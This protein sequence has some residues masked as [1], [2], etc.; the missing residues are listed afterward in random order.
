MSKFWEG[1][2]QRHVI[3]VAAIYLIVGWIVVQVTVTAAPA[4]NLP[5]WFDTGIIFLVILGFPIALVLAWAFEVT[6]EGVKRSG[7]PGTRTEGLGGDEGKP[8]DEQEDAKPSIAVMPFANLSDDKDTEHLADGMTED[9]ITGLACN[10]HLFV[11]SRNATFVYKGKPIDLREV[12]RA[13]SVRYVLEG[14]VR[15]VGDRLRTTAQLIESKTG[16][17]LWAEKFDRPKVDIFDIQDEVI[18]EILGALGAQLLSAEAKRTKGRPTESL[19]AWELT[20]QAVL[21]WQTGD[22]K[23]DSSA[24]GLLEKAIEID[25]DYATAHALLA[26]VLSGIV[27]NGLSSNPRDDF[28]LAQDHLG[29]AISLDPEDP[30]TLTWVGNTYVYFGQH[31]KAVQFLRK[32]L[33]FNPTETVTILHLA[34]AHAYLGQFEESQKNFALARRLAPSGGWSSAYD[35]YEAQALCLEGRLEEAEVQLD[36]IMP[37]NQVYA[38]PV[39]YLGLVQALQGRMDEAKA[40]VKRSLSV[41]SNVSFS[42]IAPMMGAHPDEAEAARRAAV[43]KEIW[44]HDDEQSAAEEG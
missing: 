28:Y 8:S 33:T 5:D 6:P 43:F 29:K 44:P 17:H 14:S 2:K 24:K 32:A 9:I 26:F 37:S 7:A 16:S 39:I 36:E 20:Q 25:P 13:L 38:S 11:A 40:T 18:E 35:W 10:P 21:F 19:D 27:V 1:L 15:Q 30:Q 34:L 41:N 3:Q 12:G 23:E 31:E 42:G 22:L 4:L